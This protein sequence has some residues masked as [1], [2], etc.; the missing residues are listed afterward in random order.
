MTSLTVYGVLAPEQ[1][2]LRVQQMRVVPRKE[3]PFVPNRGM[4]GVIFLP[5]IPADNA[6]MVE[7][8][9]SLP[10]PVTFNRKHK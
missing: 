3:M 5:A 4:R 6:T 1:S 10:H 8:D 2:V 9:A 7:N